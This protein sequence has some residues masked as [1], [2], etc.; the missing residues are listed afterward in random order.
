MRFVNFKQ[1]FQP[2]ELTVR[3][4]GLLGWPA[5]THKEIRILKKIFKS[6]SKDQTIHIFE[7]GMGFSTVYFAKFLKKSGYLFE[8]H[9]VDNNRF[10][11]EK[12]SAMIKDQHLQGNVTLHLREF[13]PFWQKPL[14]D[15]TV[16]P[17]CQT[18]A[19][20]TPAE[21]EYI[22][23]PQTLNLPF[24]VILVDGRFRRRCLEVAF[25]SVDHRGLVIMHDAQKKHYQ[26]PT[27]KYRYSRF[28]DS[29]RY[30]PFS[31]K[32]FQLWVGSLMN[33]LVDKLAAE[34]TKK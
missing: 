3:L 12:V 2:F 10:W 24:N 14:W 20:Q 31:S 17:K 25:G 8:M 32:K 34:F 4:H 21:L 9:A 11:Y 23:L 30:F 33:P 5:M 27:E 16:E 18:F 6:F 19:A 29:G 7:Y 15:W 26:L 28:I 22:H 1:K 13:S